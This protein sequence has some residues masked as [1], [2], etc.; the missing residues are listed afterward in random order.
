M[1]GLAALFIL[2]AT[3]GADTVHA[4]D[5]GVFGGPSLAANLGSLPE[6]PESGFLIFGGY[7]EGGA[8]LFEAIEVGPRLGA[9]MAVHD[10]EVFLTSDLLARL[11]FEGFVAQATVGP[12][13]I[14]GLARD[15]TWDVYGHASLGLG[16]GSGPEEPVGVEGI[17]EAGYIFGLGPFIGVNVGFPIGL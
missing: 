3:V 7:A 16:W 8:R 17:V 15:A 14:G 5:I 4:G 9:H 10:S 12:W 13:V 1:R 2:I 11:R 6:A